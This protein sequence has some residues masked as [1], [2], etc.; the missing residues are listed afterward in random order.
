MGENGENMEEAGGK[1]IWLTKRWC[2]PCTLRKISEWWSMSDSDTYSSYTLGDDPVTTHAR[3]I[4]KYR[5][6]SLGRRPAALDRLARQ[7]Q[8][9][10]HYSPSTEPSPCLLCPARS[11]ALCMCLGGCGRDFLVPRDV[12]PW[13]SHIFT[14][15]RRACITG[16]WCLAAVI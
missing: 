2:K 11:T 9:A 15:P 7:S 6:W 8:C 16:K 13:S 1:N 5:R 14:G 12:S 10:R 4:P 3:V